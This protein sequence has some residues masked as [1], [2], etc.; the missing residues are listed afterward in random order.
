MSGKDYTRYF[1]GKLNTKP[2]KLFANALSTFNN[3]LKWKN[4][5]QLTHQS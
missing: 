2:R 4:Q 3:S 5:D 1:I